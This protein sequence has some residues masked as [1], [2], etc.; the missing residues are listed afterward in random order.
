MEGLQVALEIRQACLEDYPAIAA[1]IVEAYGALAPYKG[2]DRW[3]WQFVDNPFASRSDN[4]VPVWIALDGARVVGQIA[5]QPTEIKVVDELRPA[6]WIVDVMVLPSF[7]GSGVGQQLY[8]ALAEQVAILITLTMAPATRRIAEHLNA[9]TLP[10]VYQFSRWRR[11]NGQLVRRYL[12]TR[13]AHRPR[14]H[15]LAELGGRVGFADLFSAL[16][17]P[18]L[19]ARDSRAQGAKRG[20]TVFVEVERFGADIDHLWQRMQSDYTFAVP[21]NADFLNWRFFDCPQMSYR[22]FVARQD[23]RTVGYVVLRRAESVELP[24]GIVVDVV[25]EQA[26]DALLSEM[27]NFSINWFGDTVGSIEFGTSIPEVASFVRGLG[28]M[29]TRTHHPTI[30]CS[31]PDLRR[32]FSDPKNTWLLSKMDHDWDQIHL[33]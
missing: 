21:R 2:Q 4:R 11:L 1:F 29:R 3:R 7:R 32:L 10:A 6:G 31:D 22:C 8:A 28:F 27:F 5:V 30:V 16:V 17:N 26:A 20:Q 15:G 18:I 14:W 12:A 13:T 19:S 9:I 25:V 23:G 24:H 33:A